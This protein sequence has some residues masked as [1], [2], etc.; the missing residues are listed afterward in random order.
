MSRILHTLGKVLDRPSFHTNARSFVGFP[1][2]RQRSLS[3]SQ[4]I[5]QWGNRPKQLQSTPL[6][7]DTSSENCQLPDLS[8]CFAAITAIPPNPPVAQDPRAYTSGRWLRSDKLERGSRY[9]ELDFNALC[10]RVLELCPGA[11]SISS[12]EKTEG[13][14]NKVFIFSMD[15]T[16]RIVARL[17]TRISGPPRLTTNSE[18]ATIKYCESGAFARRQHSC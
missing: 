7:G 5:Y 14:Y 10:K 1:T 2:Y 16:S 18:V 11:R 17:P 4:P 13:G 9:I 8:K 3:F 15:N 6:S 12:Y